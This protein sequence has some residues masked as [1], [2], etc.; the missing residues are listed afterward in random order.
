MA[1]VAFAW[2][3]LCAIGWD[4]WRVPEV[5]PGRWRALVVAPLLAAVALGAAVTGLAWLGA[6]EWGPALLQAGAGGPAAATAL[7]RTAW[8]VGA[9]TVLGAVVLVLARRRL[10]APLSP[11]A[12]STLGLLVVAD[13][14]VA[15]RDPS[16]LAPPDVFSYRPP[17]VDVIRSG[18]RSRVYS[19]DYLDP[20]LALRQRPLPAN[21][22]RLLTAG[23]SAPVPWAVALAARQRLYPY[24]MGVFGLEGSF[25]RDTLGLYPNY[26]VWLNLAERATEGTATLAKVLRLGSVSHVVALHD[27]GFED[28]AP[29]ARLPGLLVEPVRVFAV[30]Q[31]MPRAYAVGGARVADGREGLRILIDPGFD[32]S[33]EV[34]LAAGVPAPVPPAF[35]GEVRA[36]EWRPDRLRLEARLDQPGYVVLAEGY[37]P[38]WRARVDGAPAEVRRANIGLRAVAVPAGTH[39]VELVYRPPSVT[40]GLAVSAL[41][42]VVAAVVGARS[43]RTA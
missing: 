18:P 30:P 23:E 19:Y 21:P 3:L 16:P 5:P 33:R 29:V 20:G 9:A 32:P 12:L 41:A 10:A 25:H 2:S 15:H 37:D 36:L 27:Q 34:L 11:L 8:H 31:P 38:G 42:L 22:E 1:L 6:D 13:L 17:V 26:L 43:R 4:A 39:L 40:A 35:Q 24:L 14:L 7:A 28:L